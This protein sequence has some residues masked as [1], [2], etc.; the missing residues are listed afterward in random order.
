MPIKVQSDLPAKE[1]LE[2]RGIRVFNATRGGNLEI[3]ERVNLDELF[4]EG[5]V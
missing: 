2:K 1:Q 5:K 4:T 3:F